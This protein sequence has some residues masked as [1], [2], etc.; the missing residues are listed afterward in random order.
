LRTTA[1]GN[2]NPRDGLIPPLSVAACGQATMA[3]AEKGIVV[4]R[5]ARASTAPIT[6]GKTIQPLPKAAP[7]DLQSKRILGTDTIR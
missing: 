3:A 7:G 5:M 6:S 4:I 1:R 2:A